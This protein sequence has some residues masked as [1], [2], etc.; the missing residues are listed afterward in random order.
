M[1]ETPIPARRIRLLGGLHIETA[2][3]AQR[4]TSRKAIQ[5][6]AYL[7]LH[8]NAP[9]SREV[10][11]DQLWPAVAPDRS[12]PSLSDAVYRLRQALGP[13]SLITADDRIALN[14]QDLWVDVWAF[15]QHLALK[16]PTTL[17][18][19]VDLYRGDLLPELSDDWLLPPRVALREKYLAALF[20]LG[21]LLEQ[22]Q[23]FAAALEA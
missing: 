12:R 15:E 19:A 16:T 21:H 13:T 22:S 3:G 9:Q 10:L 17:R 20:E 6:L 2:A 11:A 4:L 18:Q 5:L 1:E 8:S 14:P 23:D 7:A